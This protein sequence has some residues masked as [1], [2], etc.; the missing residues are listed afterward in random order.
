ML[1][2]TRSIWMWIRGIKK[3]IV[4]IHMYICTYKIYAHIYTW[5]RVKACKL[6]RRTEMWVSLFFLNI[7]KSKYQMVDWSG[8]NVF[9]TLFLNNCRLVSIER[10]LVTLYIYIYL[11]L[12]I[13]NIILSLV[14]LIWDKL[15]ARPT[16]PMEAFAVTLQRHCMRCVTQSFFCFVFK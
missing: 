11:Y 15:S 1:T 8:S 10:Q 2:R 5:N 12:Y 7:V 4:R 6:V 3:F 9:F 13:Y 16:V 14:S